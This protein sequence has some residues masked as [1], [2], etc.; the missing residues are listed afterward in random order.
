MHFAFEFGIY[1]LVL[2]VTSIM[3]ESE[4]CLFGHSTQPVKWNSVLVNQV[5]TELLGLRSISLDMLVQITVDAKCIEHVCTPR[6]PNSSTVTILFEPLE[7]ALFRKIS[8]W[9]M[10]V[11]LQEPR[12]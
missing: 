10:Q 6:S 5:G 3:Q 12:S 8:S 11:I 1:Q 2:Q 4:N 9:K 7:N